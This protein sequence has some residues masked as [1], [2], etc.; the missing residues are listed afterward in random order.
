[1]DGASLTIQESDSRLPSM[2]LVWRIEPEISD[3]RQ[4]FLR[5]R[6]TIVPDIQQGSYPF[7]DVQLTRADIE[8]LLLTHEQGRGPVKWSDFTQQ[9]RQGID[10]RGANIQH[11]NLRNLPLACV[12]G[13]LTQEEWVATTQ[14]QRVLAGVHLEQADLSGAHLEGALL[15]GA[16]L[17]SVSLRAALLERAVLFQAHLEGAYLR[18]AHL[19]G[20]NMM[21]AHL[22]GAYLRK[23]WLTGVDLRHAICDNT[24]NLEKVTLLNKK[25]GCVLLADVHWGDCNLALLNWRHVLPL[26]DETLAQQLRR[27]AKSF[28]EK[29]YALDVSQAAGRAY[30]QLA[31]AMRA[32]GM[33]EE[34]MPFAYRAQV[35]QRTILRRRLLWG[36]EMFFEEQQTAQTSVRQRVRELR[37]RILIGTSYLFSWFLDIIAGYGYKPERGLGLYLLTILTFTLVYHFAGTLPFGQSL[38]FSVTAFHGRGFLIG[39]FTLASPVTALAALEAVIGLFIEISF[40]ATF[41]QRFFGR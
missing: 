30:R 4:A 20:A 21:Y 6:L 9:A 16:F 22:E 8:W 14:T 25:W 35:L 27:S 37:H 15:R 28:K 38:I 41:T 26:G 5:E 7:K 11:V 13:G 3:A 31:N 33:N 23:A 2:T 17:Q 39:P 24:T 29:H 12:R 32:Q 40:I 34:A 10:L 1:M 36:S 19:E 18:K